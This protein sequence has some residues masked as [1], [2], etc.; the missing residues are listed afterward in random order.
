MCGFVYELSTYFVQQLALVRMGYLVNPDIC[1]LGGTQEN[2]GDI[3]IIGNTQY[4]ESYATRKAL[5]K[6]RLFETVENAGTDINYRC[7]N[8]RNCSDC[9]KSEQIQCISIQEEI[10]QD[11]ID[12]SVYVQVES[13]ITIA[14][15]PFLENPLDKLSPNREKAMAVYKGQVKKLD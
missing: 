1:L 3:D 10:E 15:L 9:R 7:V 4:G 8:C 11:I 12:N 6:S 2:F 5:K 14:K 13:G